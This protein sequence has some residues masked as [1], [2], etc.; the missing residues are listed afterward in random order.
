LP[1]E[2]E[3]HRHDD[4][5]PIRAAGSQRLANRPL[6]CPHESRL[7]RDNPGYAEIIEAHAIA[8]NEDRSGYLDP[9]TGLFVLSAA[10]LSARGYCCDNGCRHCPYV[11]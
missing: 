5:S 7:S 2:G 4:S 3:A 9:D 8:L 1:A 11:E 6:T 10:Y